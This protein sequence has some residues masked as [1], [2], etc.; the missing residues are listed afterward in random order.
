MPEIVCRHCHTVFQVDESG[1]AETLRQIRDKEFNK[2]MDE[3]LA[4]AFIYWCRTK[5][6]EYAVLVADLH[7]G[8]LSTARLY[9]DRA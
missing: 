9:R 7:G 5:L 6:F 8:D 3:H 4:F 2:Q 1:Y